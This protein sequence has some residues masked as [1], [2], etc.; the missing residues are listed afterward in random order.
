VSEGVKHAIT[1]SLGI[2][3]GHVTSLS[4]PLELRGL[5]IEK[6]GAHTTIEVLEAQPLE[7]VRLLTLTSELLRSPLGLEVSHS[8]VPGLTR[9][10]IDI[11]AVLV[12][13]LSPVG[14]FETLEDSPGAT[15]ERYISNTLKK[16]VGVEVLSVDMM[17]N[18]RLLVELIAIDV[19]DAKSCLSCLLDMESVCNEEEVGVNETESL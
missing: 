3:D 2:V 16:S 6:T 5:V 11:P 8:V 15:V 13:V 12:L 14:N 1:L 7:R 9:V 17:H 18:I 19:L 4:L 10:S